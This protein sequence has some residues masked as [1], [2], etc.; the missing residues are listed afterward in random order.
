MEK[1]FNV[2]GVAEVTGD[3]Q[4]N[5]F[6]VIF[7]P[8]VYL[9][10]NIQQWQEEK[11]GGYSPYSSKTSVLMLKSHRMWTDPAHCR[12]Q[13]DSFGDVADLFTQPA[14]TFCNTHRKKK[15]SFSSSEKK[16]SVLANLCN[17]EVTFT[18]CMNL[19]ELL[20]GWSLWLLLRSGSIDSFCCWSW[21]Q[22]RD[23]ERPP[24]CK[25]KGN[26]RRNTEQ[27]WNR[28]KWVS[29]SQLTESSTW[30]SGTNPVTQ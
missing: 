4:I 30:P 9:R 22:M 12:L 5:N 19:L 28:G 11:E 18:S 23:W 1:C 16:L 3:S 29:E 8:G 17:Q 24:G 26:S 13:C 10:C 2:W 21:Q 7:T 15:T 14:D 20:Y 27:N 25:R 6:A